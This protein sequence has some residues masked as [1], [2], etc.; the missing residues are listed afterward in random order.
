M[1]TKKALVTLLFFM[2][3][4][5]FMNCNKN[6]YR[7]NGWYHI[8][9]GQKDNIAHEPIVTVKDFVAL[10]LDSDVFGKYIITGQISEHKITKWMNET[11][12]AMGKQIAFVFNDSVITN[13]TVNCRIESG[14][15][16]ISSLLDDKLPTIYRQLKK[17]M[18]TNIE[19]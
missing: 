13:P 10:R 15:F 3:A 5:C 4:L 19:K 14:A 18:H 7:I 11:E 17:E 12:K 2:C 8:I 16:Q 1:R 9:P 6:S